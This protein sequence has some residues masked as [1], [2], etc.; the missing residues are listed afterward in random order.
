MGKG[1]RKKEDALNTGPSRPLREGGKSIANQS[2]LA[3]TNTVKR[4]QHMQRL[5]VWAAGEGSI[6]PVGALLGTHFQ[7]LEKL[8]GFLYLI[9][10]FHL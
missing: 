3:Y 2:D 8:R 5:A 1:G 6:P 9:L 10:I 7:L 4:M